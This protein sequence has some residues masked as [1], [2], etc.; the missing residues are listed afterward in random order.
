MIWYD[1][2]ASNAHFWRRSG[3]NSSADA[4][5]KS[6][7]TMRLLV[8]AFIKQTAQHSRIPAAQCKRIR[9]LEFVPRET[10]S[11]N[12]VTIFCLQKNE[13]RCILHKERPLVYGLSPLF[14][15]KGRQSV[16]AR[17]LFFYSFLS[18]RKVR[19]DIIVSII[20]AIQIT[21][22]IIVSII[23]NLPSS[24]IQAKPVEFGRQP[25]TNGRTIIV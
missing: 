4:P 8:A 16:P 22:L 5:A 14:G 11:P 12:I 9:G 7:A 13:K 23:S 1:F 6:W 18:F 2:R 15:L 17:R 25:P 24:F 19:S 21:T 10:N 3:E 20:V